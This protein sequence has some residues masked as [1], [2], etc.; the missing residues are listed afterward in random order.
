DVSAEFL[1][2]SQKQLELG[3]LSPLDIYNPQQQLAT[4]EVSVAQ[5]RFTLTEREDALRKQIAA[6]LDPQ[7]R[8][9]PLVLTD[10]AEMPLESINFER[11]AAIQQALQNRPDLKQAVQ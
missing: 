5:A 2:L 11:E 3:A 8:T 10:T 4:N 7:V 1:K 9:L 6:D